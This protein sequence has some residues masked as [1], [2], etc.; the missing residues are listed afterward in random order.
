MS[1]D[2]L[3]V[4]NLYKVSLSFEQKRGNEFWKQSFWNNVSETAPS[5]LQNWSHQSRKASD[6][7]IGAGDAKRAV[8]AA[9]TYL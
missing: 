6:D 8:P 2:K 5:L 1:F 7:Q 3:L 4:S 9:V